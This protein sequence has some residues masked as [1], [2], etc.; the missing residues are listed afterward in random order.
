MSLQ[1]QWMMMPAINRAMTLLRRP[2]LSLIVGSFL[3]GVLRLA[4]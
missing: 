3:C 4:D 1:S 2:V